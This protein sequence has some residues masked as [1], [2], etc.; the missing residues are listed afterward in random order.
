VIE[1]IA[2]K[3][4]RRAPRRWIKVYPFEPDFPQDLDGIEDWYIHLPFCRGKC[5]YCC[6]RSF[7]YSE[8]KVK[9]Y[10]DAVKREISIYRERLGDISIGDIHFGGGTPS[11]T[12]EG[13]I[14]LIDYLRSNFEV[15]GKIGIEANPEDINQAMCNALLDSGVSM[16]SLGV[17]S[18]NSELLRS[19]NRGYYD[20]DTSLKAIEL[21]LD[22][23][24]H[25]SIDLLYGLP[26]QDI[27]SF[28]SDLEKAAKTEVHQ[29]CSYPL[30]LIP[31]TR[32]YNEVRKGKI[33]LPEKKVRKEMLYTMC[34]FLS[35]NGY[36]LDMPWNFQHK[37][38][39]ANR[40]VTT[41]ESGKSTIGVGVSSFSAIH[42]GG[43][44]YVNTYSLKEY[45]KA[46]ETGFPIAIGMTP[47]LAKRIVRTRIAQYMR[48]ISSSNIRSRIDKDEFE[49]YFEGRMMDRVLLKGL[50]LPLK[51]FGL[52]KEDS[53]QI[54]LTKKGI[55]RIPAGPTSNTHAGWMMD[56]VGKVMGVILHNPWPGGNPNLKR[57]L[58]GEDMAC[59][60]VNLIRRLK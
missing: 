46:T 49:R 13:V 50:L 31:Y 19:M 7:R 21:L 32:W 22:K 56:L 34:D 39:G 23:G 48:S 6:F 24:F 51:L 36:N 16:V 52:V 44:F 42:N 29:I 9:P 35:A 4:L 3:M 53:I 45:I 59:L 38:R 37:V 47:P 14:E 25:A 18:F 15:K 54:E 26:G 57:R 1:T 28:L 20:G 33:K 43:L 12:W 10:I 27:S 2:D 41:M 60:K 17:E 58:N 40:Y 8:E 55:G 11:L 30:G 5:P